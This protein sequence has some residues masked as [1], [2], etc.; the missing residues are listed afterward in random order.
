MIKTRVQE[1][2]RGLSRIPP[3]WLIVIAFAILK[4]LVHLFTA[5]NYGYLCDE[6]YAI[7]MSKHLAFGYV[8]MPPIMPA[9]LAANRAVLGDSLFAIHILPAIAGSAT[10]VLVCLIVREL[11]GR[12][13][14]TALGAAAFLVIPFYLMMNSIFGYDGFDQLGLIAFLY[15]LVQLIQTE[16]QRLWIAL[17]L[18]GGIAGMTKV[19][20]LYLAPGLLAALLATKLRKQFLTRWPW[21]GL[22]VFL[23]VVSPY[24]T[25]QALNSWPTLEYWLGYKS[26]QLQD[27]TIPEFMLNTVLGMNPLLVPLYLAGLGWVFLAR[28]GKRY[29]G[30]GILFLITLSFLFVLQA[31]YFMLAELVVFLLAAGSVFTEQLLDG[32]RWRSAVQAGAVACLLAAGILAAPS[33]LPILEPQSMEQYGEVF[34]FL[35]KPAK[36]GP[37]AATNLPVI[38]ENR[39][40]WEDLARAVADVYYD[41]PEAERATVGI[42]ADWFGPAGAINHYGEQYGLPEAVSGHLT[43]YLWGPGSDWEEMIIVTLNI[44]QFRFFFE[45]IQKKGFYVN[46]YA[47]PISTNIGIYVA[48]KPKWD[49]RNIW[50][51]VK[52]YK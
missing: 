24:L 48:R 45:D 18:V 7:D 23:A 15:L 42:Y 43:Y 25:W 46:E 38:L 35:Y 16:N 12:L 33:H 11:G 10:L 27:V 44:D 21:A 34:G 17:G 9:L 6:L 52:M 8:D 19:T 4:M 37:Y 29:A 36:I 51:M 14:A 40:G 20:I 22:G 41:L 3:F 31:K 50:P 28:D 2:G 30:L 32:I 1:I 26:F 39:V 49:I 5:A 47:S 13:F